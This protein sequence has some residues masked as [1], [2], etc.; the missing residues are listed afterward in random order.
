MDLEAIAEELGVHEPLDNDDLATEGLPA[1][2]ARCGELIA[3]A[4]ASV[5][6]G[7]RDYREWRAKTTN[8]ILAADPKLAEW[9][10]AARINAEPQFNT[11]K[12]ILADREA[13]LATLRGYA[14]ALDA[15][16]DLVVAL[17]P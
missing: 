8:A 11:F 12:G 6:V 2:L 14:Q 9:K 10:T 5:A 13:N 7:E 16:V 4:A 3:D 17:L 1:A 15:K